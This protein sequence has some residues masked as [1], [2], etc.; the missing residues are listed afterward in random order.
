MIGGCQITFYKGPKVSFR[1]TV[2]LLSGM[3]LTSVIL[4]F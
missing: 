3:V 4:Y 2:I 1:Q